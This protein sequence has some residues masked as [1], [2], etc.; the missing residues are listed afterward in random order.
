[1]PWGPAVSFSISVKVGWAR[2][3]AGALTNIPVKW[4]ALMIVALFGYSEFTSC[5][6]VKKSDYVYD[7]YRHGR[8]AQTSH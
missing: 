1:L 5:S 8:I 3:W 6:S 7:R 2:V 4:F